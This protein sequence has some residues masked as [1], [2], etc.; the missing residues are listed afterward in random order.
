MTGRVLRSLGHDT[1]PDGQP[2][3]GGRLIDLSVGATVLFV[4]TSVASV[5]APDVFSPIAV[6]VAVGLFAIGCAAF[7]LAFAQSLERSREEELSVAGIYL[8]SDSAPRIIRILLLVPPVVQTV[9]AIAAAAM[10]P[11]TAQAFGILVPM[12]GLGLAGLWAA[13]YGSFGTRKNS[14]RP[15][16]STERSDG[17]PDG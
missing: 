8:L 15:T 9:V 6:V 17:E 12:F 11:F 2:Y 16:I 1:A 3:E 7:L 14:R 4:I 5:L 10:R 13:R